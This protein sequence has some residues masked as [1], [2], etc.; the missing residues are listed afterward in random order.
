MELP[1]GMGWGAEDALGT[2]LQLL[3]ACRTLGDSQAGGSGAFGAVCQRAG[4]PG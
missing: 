3:S 4:A 1:H 2:E